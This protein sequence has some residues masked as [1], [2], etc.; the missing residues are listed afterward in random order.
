MNLLSFSEQLNNTSQWISNSGGTA[1]LS[2]ITDPFGGN[3]AYEISANGSNAWSG[4][5]DTITGILTTGKSYTYS[6]YLKKGT[7]T[8]SRIVLYDSNNTPDPRMT[9]N[10]NSDGVPSVDEPNDGHAL[11]TKIETVGDNGWYRVA[12]T[13]LALDTSGVQSVTIEP[14]RNSTGKTVY[15]LSL[16]HI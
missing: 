10:W 9:V 8:K 13:G 6:I 16:I 14:D 7:S 1:T 15:A 2:T 4:I 12:F 11:N 3:N 5:Y